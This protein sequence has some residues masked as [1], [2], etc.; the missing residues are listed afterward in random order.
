MTGAGGPAAAGDGAVRDRAAS[1]GADVL[2]LGGGAAGCVLAA[3]LSEDPTRRVTLVEAGPDYGA[4][5]NGWPASLL[6][7]SRLPRDHVWDRHASMPQIR[8]RVLGGSSAINGCWHTWGS[9]ADHRRWQ[10]AAGDVL[11]YHTL[12]P[13]RDRAVHT[14]RLT[15]VLDADITVWGR[16][17][18]LAA[19]RLGFPA[20]DMATPGPVGR[21]TPLVNAFAGTRRNVALGYLTGDVRARGNLTVVTD[22]MID[23]LLVDGAVGRA[24]R[25]RGVQ[26]IGPAGPLIFTADHVLLTAGT[27]GSP[28]VLQRSGIGDAAALRQVGIDP[29]VNLPGVGAN[30]SDQPGSF[31]ALRPTAELDVALAIHE[32]AGALYSTRV[33][34]RAGSSYAPADGWDLHLLPVAGGPLFGTLPPGRYEA[35]LSAQLMNPVSRGTVA[36]P[37]ADPYAPVR[38]DPGFL[39]DPDGDDAAVL[40]EG[41]D[42][43]DELANTPELRRWWSSA[44]GPTDRSDAALRATLGCYWHPVGTCAAGGDDQ[45]AAVVDTQ[46]RVRGLANLR[47]VDASVLP[48]TPAANT[49]LTILALAELVASELVAG[50][51]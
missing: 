28:A 1:D 48:A 21:G 5:P 36:V 12:A 15:T 22:S 46:M 8:G 25:V 51:W 29:I 39:T 50:R 10:E 31:V 41:L 4:A 2:V 45:T 20:V 6:D 11:S 17:A 26:V 24:G 9:A 44:A 42:L 37:S 43:V 27:F 7:A 34:V 18:L 32:T 35:G 23:R 3:R 19:D 13:H 49:Q 33:L 14:L 47:I 38:I 40:R 16:S 30:L